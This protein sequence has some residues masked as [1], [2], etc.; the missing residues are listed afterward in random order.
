MEIE[1]ENLF[2][3]VLTM[4]RM[5]I[6]ASGGSGTD[7]HDCVMPPAVPALVMPPAERDGQAR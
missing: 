6:A 7:K 4:I 3:N 5:A 2:K 1:S